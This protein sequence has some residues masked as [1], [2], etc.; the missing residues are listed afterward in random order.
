MGIAAG[1]LDLE[2]SEAGVQR[3]ANWQG[4]LCGPAVAFHPIVPGV[5]GRDIRSESRLPGA[6]FRMPDRLTHWRSLDGPPMGKDCARP[7]GAGKQLEIDW[8]NPDA[9]RSSA[10]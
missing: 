6:L 4:G 3:V 1:T 2:I 5:A 10:A 9:E 8:V 7:A